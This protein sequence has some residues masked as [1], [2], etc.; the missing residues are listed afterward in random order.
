MDLIWLG[1]KDWKSA[2]SP[3]SLDLSA[4]IFQKDDSSSGLRVSLTDVFTKHTHIQLITPLWRREAQVFRLKIAISIDWIYVCLRQQSS[5]FGYSRIFHET[6]KTKPQ[7]YSTQPWS[8]A[9]QIS[10]TSYIKN[11]V[12]FC[13][14]V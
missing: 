10:L 5:S 1:V 11:V 9:A 14:I 7:P 4:L 12:F 13:L 8:D 3:S 6:G 2:C